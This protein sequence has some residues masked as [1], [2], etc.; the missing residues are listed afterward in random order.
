MSKKRIPQ[1]RAEFHD[2][3]I[4]AKNAAA[5]EGEQNIVFSF[6]G[7]QYTEYFNLDAT[8]ERWSV[9]LIN[10]LKDVS[11]HTKVEL[12]SGRYQT[13]RIHH[14][15]K[16]AQIPDEIPKE[17]DPDDLYQIRI[18]K[19][20]GGIHGIFVDNI[21]YIIWFDPLHNM[22]PD[23]RF[24]GKRKIK[25]PDNCCIDNERHIIRLQEE[26][27]RLKGELKAALD[28]LGEHGGD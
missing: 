26:N 21:F 24:G 4:F 2:K 23:S 25:P 27:D 18:A 16:S 5:A 9:D 22:Y 15:G 3:R 12:L 8:C 13:L 28:L 6:E 14:H 11:K 19:G 20:K 17:I 1:A 10:R 7:L